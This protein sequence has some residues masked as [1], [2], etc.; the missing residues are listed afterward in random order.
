MEAQKKKE[1][2]EEEARKQEEKVKE[3]KV[4]AGEEAE[5]LRKEVSGL[6]DAL[7]KAVASKQESQTGKKRPG[8]LRS[9]SANVNFCMVI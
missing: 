7:R 6:K 3:E 8:P 1:E 9:S 2:E 5:R 4:K